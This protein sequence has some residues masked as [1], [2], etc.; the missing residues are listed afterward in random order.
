MLLNIHIL[1]HCR[2]MIA[3]ENGQRTIAVCLALKACLM[4][5]HT[6]KKK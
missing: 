1:V 2:L 3:S 5:R 4:A 6:K